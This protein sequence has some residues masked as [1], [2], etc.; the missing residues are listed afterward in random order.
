MDSFAEGFCVRG[1]AQGLSYADS[2][3]EDFSGHLLEGLSGASVVELLQL[4]A[5]GAG[6][7]VVA[8]GEVG[9]FV[10]VD[11]EGLCAVV[12]CHRSAVV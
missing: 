9:E 10:V 7:R 1:D 3:G 5:E 11:L 2:A 4:F 8:L 12:C 6:S